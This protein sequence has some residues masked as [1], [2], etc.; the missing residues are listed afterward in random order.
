MTDKDF[1]EDLNKVAKDFNATIAFDAVAGELTSTLSSS[2]PNNSTIYVYG[3]L[4][5]QPISGL[6]IG[7]LIFK[8]NRVFGFWLVEYGK[9]YNLKEMWEMGQH[10]QKNL[11]TIFKTK[12]KVFEAEHFLEAIENSKNNASISKS[13]LKFN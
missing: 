6:S 11:K 5:G 9:N 10:I 3:G 8:N 2:M 12:V 7:D 13:I 4:S 1:N